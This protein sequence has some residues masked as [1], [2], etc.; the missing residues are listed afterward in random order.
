V[1][2]LTSD[3]G[4]CFFKLAKITQV[5]VAT[6]SVIGANLVPK[7]T[8]LG[9]EPGEKSSTPRGPPVSATPAPQVN[10]TPQQNIEITKLQNELARAIDL[11][12]RQREDFERCLNSIDG[13]KAGLSTCQEFVGK[14]ED[15]PFLVRDELADTSLVKKLLAEIER[16][17]SRIKALEAANES[18]RSVDSR[19]STGRMTGSLARQM[20]FG[21]MI[22]SNLANPPAPPGRPIDRGLA[23][24]PSAGPP[25][26]P[27]PNGVTMVPFTS[28]VNRG[29][30]RP[31]PQLTTQ[32]RQLTSQ[33]SSRPESS[34][35]TL[36]GSNPNTVA[37]K[38]PDEIRSRYIPPPATEN[39]LSVV[40][41][42]GLHRS[43]SAMSTN[44]MDPDTQ[45]YLERTVKQDNEKDIDYEP[46]T[47]GHSP[48]GQGYFDEPSNNDDRD[49][50][51]E[52]LTPERLRTT[53]ETTSA[54]PRGSGRGG[55][56]RGPGRGR[57]RGMHAS[58]YRKSF[59]SPRTP[60]SEESFRVAPKETASARGSYDK[61][62]GMSSASKFTQGLKRQG[63]TLEKSPVG[64]GKKKKRLRDEEG[65]LLRAD[66][67]RDLRSI[68]IS[69][70]RD[71]DGFLLRSDGKRDM[72]SV[73]LRKSVDGGGNASSTHS[74]SSSPEPSS[75]ESSPD[76]PIGMGSDKH[77]ELMNKIFPERRRQSK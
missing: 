76:R 36:V 31:G 55:R 38:A 59:G 50:F 1:H 23:M 73:R 66:G 58:M 25:S 6:G 27:G 70:K 49:N 77:R 40:A 39:R 42:N 48:K 46:S 4:K 65:Y 29:E 15:N 21:G 5:S 16:L 60:A 33:Q 12:E 71:E 17:S 14:A 22:S 69:R 61:S 8:L 18:R 20:P 68:P 2:P 19:Q 3:R 10:G 28:S 9:G 44:G 35:G 7:G 47:R 43:S 45:E 26:G 75:E 51:L 41:S 67:Q 32:Q 74:M 53:K 24:A 72:R 54:P 30:L 62:R 64:S 63:S 52:P 34:P 11:I 56:P 57:A 13:L 37:S